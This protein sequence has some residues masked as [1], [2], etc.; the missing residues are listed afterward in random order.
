M[1]FYL[2]SLKK[3][4]E[5]TV[6]TSLW[7]SIFQKTYCLLIPFRGIAILW[8]PQMQLTMGISHP[9]QLRFLSKT[10]LW[11]SKK[12]W[13][14]TMFHHFALFSQSMTICWLL[15]LTFWPSDNDKRHRIDEEGRR[16]HPARHGSCEG[17]L[18]QTWGS[19]AEVGMSR[20]WNMWFYRRWSGIAGWH[21]WF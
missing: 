10:R 1:K 13:F 17:H 16:H 12:E 9:I 21:M 6:V 3:P 8:G 2:S 7:T 5:K 19:R 11:P 18:D 14:I 20:T 15:S 4:C